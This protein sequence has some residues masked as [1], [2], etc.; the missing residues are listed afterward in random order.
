MV[1]KFGT[2]MSTWAQPPCVS[3]KE[4]HMEAKAF[5]VRVVGVWV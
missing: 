5:G 1:I 2:V 4:A 3:V